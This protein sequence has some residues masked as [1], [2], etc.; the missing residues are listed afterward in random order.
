MIENKFRVWCENEKQWET[1][2]C[3]IS[4]NGELFTLLSGGRIRHANRST[5]VVE[6]FTGLT[7]DNDISVYEGDLINSTRKGWGGEDLDYKNDVV[8]FERGAFRIRGYLL[9]E[10]H[11]YKVVG[12]IHEVN[13]DT[14]GKETRNSVRGKSV[15]DNKELMRTW[16]GN[17]KQIKGNPFGGACTGY[18]SQTGKCDIDN[19]NCDA[20]ATVHTKLMD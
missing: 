10:H 19:R 13:D 6:M 2:K 12:N 4:D 7:D 16:F 3:F 11:E 8:K 20:C 15:T 17:N 18:I 9:T 1:D 5:H 14:V